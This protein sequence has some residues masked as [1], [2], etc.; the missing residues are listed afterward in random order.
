[1]LRAR[2]AVILC[3]IALL[4]LGIVMVTSAGLTVEPESRITVQGILTSRTSIYAAAAVVALLMGMLV[5]VDWIVAGRGLMKPLWWIVGLCL[6]LLMLVFVPGVG[7]ARYG[8]ARWIRVG[9]PDWS[10]TFQPSEMAKWLMPLI[11]GY[12]IRRRGMDLRAFWRGLFPGLLVIG[13]VCG[14]IITQD[15][16]TAVLIGT[17]SLIL[18][19]AAGS[20]W[21]HLLLLLPGPVVVVGLA[22][23]IEPYRI[24]R[25][26][27]FLNPYADPQGA[28]YHIIQALVAI[29]S[30]NFTGRGLGH[31]IQK[32]GYLPVDTSDFIF[33]VICE[34]LG[35]F[36]AA[37]VIFLYCLMVL[38][39]L[40]II[41]KQVSPFR[42]IIALG[43]ICTFGL[44]AAMNLLVVTAL[45][46]TK[47]IALPLLSSGGT[48]WLLTALSLGVLVRMD[49]QTEQGASDANSA[50]NDLP[51][52][53]S[54]IAGTTDSMTALSREARS[55]SVLDL[56]RGVPATGTG[57][58]AANI[59]PPI[60]I[61]PE[62]QTTRH[63]SPG[64]PSI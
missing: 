7:D 57:E 43:I 1:M 19:W 62:L 16:G 27:T 30:G 13:G 49:W 5:D 55:N 12:Y 53:R 35:I 44:Q 46:P 50:G 8:S 11:M 39:G 23:W 25:I 37:L 24:D 36:G 21:W 61:M 26:R 64:V 2:H 31:G 3:A 20:R 9:P 60:V 18:L 56:G 34:E 32:F 40:A 42:Q 17:V 41:R 4:T 52:L 28:G 22:V 6:I 63:T 33:A 54:L 29:M 10:L 48:G 58:N 38:A 45:I 15:L 59:T 47:G 51:V 14:I